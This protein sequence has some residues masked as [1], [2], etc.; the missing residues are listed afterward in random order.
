MKI[1]IKDEYASSLSLFLKRLTYEDVYRRTDCG[2][3]AENRK[4]QTYYFLAGVSDVE[5]AVNQEL[6]KQCLKELEE[7]E[8]LPFAFRL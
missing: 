5:R 1:E 3:T 4:A 2:F 8:K 7:E 6:H